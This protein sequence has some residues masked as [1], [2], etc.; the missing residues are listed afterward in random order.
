MSKFQTTPTMC[1]FMNDPTLSRRVKRYG[2]EETI[3]YYEAK[4][5]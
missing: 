2:L 4:R 5:A 1:E 3:K